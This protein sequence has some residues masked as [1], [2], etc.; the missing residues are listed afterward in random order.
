MLE[1]T[2]LKFLKELAKNNNK[3]W[4]DA[5]RKR[6]EAAR[7]DFTQ[8]AAGIIKGFCKKDPDFQTLE[9]RKCLFRINRDV[10][11]SKD[12]SPYKTNF[13]ASFERGGRISPYAAYYLH[14]EP[15]NKS[16]IAGGVWQPEAE[17]VK[18]IRQEI[19]YNWDAFRK[20]IRNKKFVSLFGDLEKTKETSLSREPKGYEKDNPAIDYLKLKS[21]VVST[22]LTDAELTDK[23]LLKKVL[24]AF[25]TMQPMIVFLN[26]ALAE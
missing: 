13:G 22:P 16:F 3:E 6:Y 5:N 25:E 10:R 8:L 7:E 2:T 1:N 20:I 26:E 18:K 17:R 21:W 4:F 11:F 23:S 12:K 9:A 15:G 24:S 14:V 19:D